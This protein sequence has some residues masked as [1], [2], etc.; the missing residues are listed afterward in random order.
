[1]LGAAVASLLGRAAGRVAL[2]QEQLRAV[3]G[4]ARTVG[5]LARQPQLAGGRGAGDLLLAAALQAV[6]GAFDDEFQQRA[7]GLGLGGEPMVE[8]VGQRLFHQLLGVGGGEAL[9][10]LALELGVG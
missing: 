1:R 8:R 6:L 9:L 10:G 2:D 3:G 5:E 4:L 7:G